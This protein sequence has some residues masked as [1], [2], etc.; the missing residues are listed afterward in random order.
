MKLI[1]IN[2][3]HGLIVTDSHTGAWPIK[4]AN[5][6]PRHQVVNLALPGSSIA[7][8]TGATPYDYSLI[9]PD[10][11]VHAGRLVA[12]RPGPLTRARARARVRRARLDRVL[13]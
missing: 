11:P 5:A 9:H 3:S 13:S 4:L 6:L 7:H 2:D 12:G 10:L 8:W 1:T